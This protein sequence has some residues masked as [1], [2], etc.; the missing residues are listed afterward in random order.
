[1]LDLLNDCCNCFLLSFI[2][3][4]LNEQII[5]YNFSFFIKKCFRN[6]S[7]LLH[8]LTYL[9]LLNSFSLLNRFSV[10]LKSLNNY[11][12]RWFAYKPLLSRFSVLIYYTM[13]SSIPLHRFS[14]EVSYGERMRDSGNPCMCSF[15]KSTHRV[16]TCC[17][18][19]SAKIVT[20]SWIIK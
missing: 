18:S 10:R 13:W 16:K 15:G 3:N 14:E 4:Y 9:S 12:C 8:N 6:L 2:K 20:R 1:M 17:V 5:Y 7:S 19:F 11:F